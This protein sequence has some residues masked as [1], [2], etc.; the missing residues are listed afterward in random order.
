MQKKK[1]NL[2]SKGNYH[3]SEE[4]PYRIYITLPDLYDRGFVSKLYKKTH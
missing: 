2:Y 4:A 3:F 1:K